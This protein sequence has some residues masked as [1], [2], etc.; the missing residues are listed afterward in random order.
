[1]ENWETDGNVHN[2]RLE[3]KSFYIK[4]VNA[5]YLTAIT[6]YKLYK[7]T[8]ISTEGCDCNK[9]TAVSHSKPPPVPQLFPT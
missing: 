9:L 4:T 8:T 6:L 1:M 7:V 3:T 2:Y 5:K